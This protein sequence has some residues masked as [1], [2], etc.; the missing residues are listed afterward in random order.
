MIDALHVLIDSEG[1]FIPLTVDDMVKVVTT[2]DR[3]YRDMEANDHM[4]TYGRIGPL[5]NRDENGVYHGAL[6]T[7]AKHN[8][9]VWVHASPEDVRAM[10]VHIA[11]STKK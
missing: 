5:L 11:A 4:L 3:G 1:D 9:K 6:I 2:I 10:R 7:H 8:Q